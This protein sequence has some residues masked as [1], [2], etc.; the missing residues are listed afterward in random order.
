VSSVYPKAAP[1]QT[2]LGPDPRAVK[3]RS[4][5]R[6]LAGRDRIEVGVATGSGGQI[7]VKVSKASL[8]ASLRRAYKRGVKTVQVSDL[9]G[10]LVVGAV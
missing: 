10:I 5:R 2:E 9:F 3:I 7:L 6:L 4:V 8:M 1:V